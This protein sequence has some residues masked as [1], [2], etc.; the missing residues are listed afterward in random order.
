M[1]FKFIRAR[2]AVA[3]IS[4][5]STL[6]SIDTDHPKDLK[7]FGI[8]NVFLFAET[9][10][11]GSFARLSK[12]AKNAGYKGLWCLYFT[13]TDGSMVSIEDAMHMAFIDALKKAI[14]L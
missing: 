12:S 9:C 2:K 3:V 6:K 8:K 1:N 5:K 4:C 13:D 11:K 14:S 10:P 7:K